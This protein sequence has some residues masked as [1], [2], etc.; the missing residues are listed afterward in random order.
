VDTGV[1]LLVLWNVLDAV[2]STVEMSRI[3]TNRDLEG[4]YVLSQAHVIT[5]VAPVGHGEAV[6]ILSDISGEGN[7]YP[8][9]TL[10]TTDGG[11]TWAAPVPL[12]G[13]GWAGAHSTAPR[14][15]ADGDRAIA[16]FSDD[17][18]VLFF[19]SEDGGRTW[20]PLPE[21]SVPELQT[22][23]VR[24][25]IRG[26]DFVI[27]SYSDP[28][29]S[30]IHLEGSLD[31][32]ATRLPPQAVSFFSRFSSH[33]IYPDVVID[34]AGVWH[35]TALAV[36]LFAELLYS[37]SADHG[38]TWSSPQRLNCRDQSVYVPYSE[39]KY[40]FA[41]GTNGVYAAWESVQDI[42]IQVHSTRVEFPAPPS[43]F[44]L[45]RLLENPASAS[46]HVAVELEAPIPT[47]LT[48]TVYDVTGRQVVSWV[49]APASAARFTLTWNPTDSLGRQLPPGVY[50][51]HLDGGAA[52]ETTVRSV[53]Y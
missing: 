11:R 30:T 9:T 39:R 51:W 16:H 18:A 4:P 33:V 52:G 8:V 32:G 10:R 25:A 42:L 3:S 28:S 53:L 46:T 22:D 37:T 47:T 26:D 38:T 48:S 41:C 20:A 29:D 49:T 43:P 45:A 1:E 40:D 15:E 21:F 27:V 12:P 19:S 17:E 24:S 13:A 23:W 31:A 2:T 6:I 44:L 5:D 14:L 35:V 36:N 50:F 7:Q 34:A